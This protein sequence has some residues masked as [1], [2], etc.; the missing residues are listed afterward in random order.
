MAQANPAEL[1]RHEPGD[2]LTR[3]YEVYGYERDPERP[4]YSIEPYVTR[5]YVSP[6]TSADA[7]LA[8]RA[9]AESDRPEL[10]WH[11]EWRLVEL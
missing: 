5:R 7:A 4:G 1:L 6:V 10:N 8:A 3:R 2:G 11:I 9:L